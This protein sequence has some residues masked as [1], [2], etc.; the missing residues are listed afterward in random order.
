MRLWSLH[1]TL[2]DPMGLV[3]LWREALLAQK[4]LQ[5]RTRGYQAHP[6]LTRFRQSHAP[7]T[8]ISDYLWAVHDEAS[9][10]DYSFDS[11]KI[12]EKRQAS[13]L[14]VT[15]GQLDFELRHLKRKLRQRHALRYRQLC[16]LQAIPPHPLFKVVAGEV[17]TWERVRAS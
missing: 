16:C 14:T 9:Q 17:E 7:L 3:A 10:R 11:S 2:L 13:H 1:P 4:V 5:G 8:A 12:A 6:Q 15:S